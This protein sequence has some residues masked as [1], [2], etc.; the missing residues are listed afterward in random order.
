MLDFNDLFPF[1]PSHMWLFI[2]EM[3]F[4]AVIFIIII[5]AC[6]IYIRTQVSHRRRHKSLKSFR[7]RANRRRRAF[8][9]RHGVPEDEDFFDEGEP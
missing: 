6:L 8:R 3:K 9:A 5:I 1:E 2:K 4:W 7:V